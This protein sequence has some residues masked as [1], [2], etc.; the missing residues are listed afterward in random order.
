MNKRDWLYNCFVNEINRMNTF[1]SVYCFIE[2]SLNP[3][4][5]TALEKRKKYEWLQEEIRKVLLLVGLD[6]G[7]DGKITST[8]RASTLDDVDRRVNSLNR[9]LY[10]RAIHSEVTKY[11]VKDYLR[12]D[13]YDAVFE[14]C[15]GLSERVKQIT[16][17][18]DDGSTLFQTAFSTKAPYLFFNKMETDSELSEFRG[19]REL[20]EAIFHMIRN[21]AAHTPKIN[22]K[23]D[24]AVCLDILTIISFAHKYLDECHPMARNA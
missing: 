8:Q 10:D 4:Q 19:L 3:I 18:T 17:L 23:A 5:Y 14:A 7:K 20:L 11:C 16:G 2:S 12:R 9:K 1:S 13:Y 15:K 22:W 24:E 21:P 6:F